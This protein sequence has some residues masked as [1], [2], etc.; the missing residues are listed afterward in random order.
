MWLDDSNRGGGEPTPA[1]GPTIRIVNSAFLD[2]DI[3]LPLVHHASA[4]PSDARV[5][6]GICAH[7][8]FVAVIDGCLIAPLPGKVRFWRR[9]QMAIG[10]LFA[11]IDGG[12]PDAE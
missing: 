1:H 2:I 11:T 4:R 9:L 6:I 7:G 5:A 10:Y 8:Q 3:D 12:K